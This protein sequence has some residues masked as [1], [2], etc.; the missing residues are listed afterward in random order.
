M[1][2]TAFIKVKT[3]AINWILNKHLA[4]IVAMLCPDAYWKKI[5]HVQQSSQN[6]IIY[7]HE[8][9]EVQWIQKWA[10]CGILCHVMLFF[11]MWC[12]PI[13]MNYYLTY[14][15]IQARHYCCV[16]NWKMSQSQG[17][18]IF[19]CLMHRIHLFFYY[20]ILN[21]CFTFSYSVSTASRKPCTTAVGIP[22]IVASHANRPIG[23]KSTNA[24]A[25][26]NANH[27]N[28][29][30]GNHTRAKKECELLFFSLKLVPENYNHQL[31]PCV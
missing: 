17:F 24:S 8:W 9:Q 10:R 15:P 13:L 3:Y 21:F 11:L 14:K 27:S 28:Q 4:L 31:K 30:H 2:E 29:R 6:N 20:Q 19:A 1:L 7:N 16:S 25:D 23:T 5:Q 26:V 18:N 12:W 22:P